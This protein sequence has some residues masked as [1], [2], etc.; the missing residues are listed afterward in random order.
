M[1]A[2]LDGKDVLV[3]FPSG[4]GENLIYQIQE[5]KSIGYLAVDISELTVS[6]IR[7]NVGP[8]L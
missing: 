5:I 4:Y 1:R 3:V 6:Q 8:K 2:P 7:Y